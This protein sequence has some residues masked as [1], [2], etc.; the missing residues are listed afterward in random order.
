[1][2]HVLAGRDLLRQ[3]RRR[4]S[5]P[6]AV[7]KRV[8]EKFTALLQPEELRNVDKVVV[9]A[10]RLAGARRAR[11]VRHRQ[12]DP[13]LALEQRV[14]HAAF[15]AAGRRRDDEQA[16]RCARTPGGDRHSRF[17]TCSRICSI[18]TLS[19]SETCDSSASTDFEPSVFASRCSSCA[20][21]SRRLPTVPPCASTRRISPIWV[22]RRATSSATSIF[23]AKNASSCFSRS[24][25]AST[26]ASARRAPSLS[27]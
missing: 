18:S 15:P 17:C 5:V 8:L 26:P 27:R 3:P 14:D 20:R 16:A 22:E 25:L 23:V 11:R 7:D 1:E 24:S 12:T 2:Q 4:C 10:F 6:I 19:S 21:K 9:V 13:R